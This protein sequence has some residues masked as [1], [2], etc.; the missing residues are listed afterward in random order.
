MQ[1]IAETTR[2]QLDGRQQRDGVL[3]FA[4]VPY[5]AAPE[6]D[7]RFRPPQPHQGWAGVRDATKFG[8]VAPQGGGATSILTAGWN[9]EYSEDCLFL[10]LQTPALDEGRRPVMVWIHGG[11]FTSGTGAIPWYDGASFVR[12][13]DVVVVSINYRLGALGFLHLGDHADDYA[14]SGN[15]GIAD[16]IAALEWV[17]D[18]IA[19]FGGD[20]GNVTIFG[21]SAGGMS[22]GT[23]LGAPA[24]NGLFHKAIAQS[25]A[26]SWVRKSED[27]AE[28]TDLMMK[29][30]GAADISDLMAA[31][32]DRLLEAQ[33]SLAQQMLTD[34]A[35]RRRGAGIGMPFQPVVDG[36]VLP[37]H[38]AK[39]TAAGLSADVPVL[40]GT[41]R[42]EFNLFMLMAPTADLPWERVSKRIA[43]FHP[44]PAQVIET[45]RE[46][47][48][49]A[50]PTEVF[51]AF[52]TARVFGIPAVRL[53]E[54]QSPHQPDNTFVYE[55][56][57]GSPAFDG[58]IGSAHALEI[59]FVWNNLDK[60]GIEMLLGDNPPQSIADAMHQAWID[61][62]RT[63]DAGWAPYSE[64]QRNVQWFDDFA[65]GKASELV[66]DPSPLE[67]ELFSDVL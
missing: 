36:E 39:A 32:T 7:L 2:G 61:F 65:G 35:L 27:A 30:L 23:L 50:G 24:A 12:Q 49:E 56:R 54:A 41:T 9:P 67:R 34:P 47:R 10:N 45:Y 53:V 25:G 37:E 63:G 14:G 66:E 42:E 11:A 59:P 52:M 58:K 48:P 15:N 40:T 57:W 13:G 5:A 60:R 51:S 38:P 31:S 29:E 64:K 16:Q 43:R 46:S 4:G 44:D 55:F 28:V 33:N 26:A 6:G 3:L 19:S 62:A 17:R 18:N 8:A 20:P 22:V 21:E 1:I